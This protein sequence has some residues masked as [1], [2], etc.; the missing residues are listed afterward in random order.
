M[1]RS[2]LATNK[3]LSRGPRKWAEAV[4]AISVVCGSLLAL[5]PVVSATGWWP[6]WGLLVLIAWR[7]L[8]ADAWPG[9]WAAPLGFFNDLVAGY[10]IGLS[11]ALWSL[12]MLLMDIIDR[13]TQWRDYWIEWAVA[14]LFIALFEV[15]QWQTAGL[16]GA[17]VPFRRN[18]HC[19][20][21]GGGSSAPLGPPLLAHWVRSYKKSER[22][23]GQLARRQAGEVCLRGVELRSMTGMRGSSN[24]KVL[25]RPGSE[26]RPMRVPSRRA[27]RSAMARPR[28]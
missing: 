3:R 13:R 5:L 14:C 21:G 4:P 7:L 16:V 20:A 1:V 23:A 19:H 2:A 26:R 12:I 9:W 15:G 10:P 25:P 24:Q 6:D 27:S 8:R 28:P 11:V 22:V 18:G 17:P